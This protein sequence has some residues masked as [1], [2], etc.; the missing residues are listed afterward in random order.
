MKQ[1]RLPGWVLAPRERHG[2]RPITREAPTGLGLGDV[3]GLW[4][5]GSI[6]DFELDRLS[7]LQ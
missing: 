2:V 1:G 6:N 5:L 4:S 3:T 7:L